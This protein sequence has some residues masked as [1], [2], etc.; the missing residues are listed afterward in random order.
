MASLSMPE[1]NPFDTVHL[2]VGGKTHCSVRYFAKKHSDLDPADIVKRLE[3]EFP[4][5]YQYFA[6]DPRKIGDIRDRNNRIKQG[7]PPP[8]R[9]KPA[10]YN[11]FSNHSQSSANS[12]GDQGG[13]AGGAG[14]GNKK[15]VS[16]AEARKN[17]ERWLPIHGRT[18]FV[19]LKKEHFDT[20]KEER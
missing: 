18:E 15:A 2:K 7:L 16:K 19:A 1:H 11:I 20:L 13:G 6:P 4:K 10:E 9:K 3:I 12:G 14:Q 17:I 8:P 5:L